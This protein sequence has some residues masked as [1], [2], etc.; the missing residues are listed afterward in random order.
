MED[1]R[2]GIGWDV[3]PLVEGRELVLGGVKIPEA[4]KGLSG[5]SDADV[6]CHALCDA[7]LGALA[8]GDI[9]EHF[10]DDDPEYKDLPSTRFLADV[11]EMVR[12]RG[13]QVAG[14][15]CTIMCDAVHIGR[16]KER[17]AANLA[18]SLGVE[19]T[20]VSVKATSWEGHGAVGRGEVIA[21]QAIALVRR[22]ADTRS[23]R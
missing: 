6:V 13:Y 12:A 10:P 7:L 17:M 21:C 20:A 11:A 8:L 5:H 19:T 14:V 1:Y 15:D 22:K 4:G 3:H 16:R 18:R 9:G 2:C 23:G